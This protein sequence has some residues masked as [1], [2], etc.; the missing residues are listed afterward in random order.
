MVLAP[1]IGKG[2]VTIEQVFDGVSRIKCGR[3]AP[4]NI[5]CVLTQR[6]KEYKQH[7]VDVRVI[8]FKGEF[9]R[10]SFGIKPAFLS[11]EAEEETPVAWGVFDAIG[12]MSCTLFDY[13]P[14]EAEEMAGKRMYC[15]SKPIKFKL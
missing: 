14:I 6:E 8:Y 7:T 9:T 10:G 12:D 3:S 4:D 2:D 13:K 5:T 1:W 11:G 15:E